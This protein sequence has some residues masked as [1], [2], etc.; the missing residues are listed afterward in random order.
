M[1]TVPELIAADETG[2]QAAGLSVITNTWAKPAA[3]H[4]HEA[5]VRAAAQA[6]V[7]LQRVIES[8]LSRL[9]EEV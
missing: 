3:F 1:S 7:S 2:M 6:S 8:I 5:V 9:E 4:G